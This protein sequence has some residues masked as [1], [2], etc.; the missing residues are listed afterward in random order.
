MRS[1]ADRAV[2]FLLSVIG[3]IVGVA[4]VA[5]IVPFTLLERLVRRW[6]GRKDKK[7]P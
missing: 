2:T 1:I 5:V 4:A 7:V 6:R 3:L